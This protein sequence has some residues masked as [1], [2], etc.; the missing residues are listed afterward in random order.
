MNINLPIILLRGTAFFPSSEI[1][2]EMSNQ[3]SKNIIDTASLFHNN[4][5]IIA[6]QYRDQ[7]LLP[8]IGVVSSIV[9][10]EEMG[11]GNIR[12]KIV[13]KNRGIIKEYLPK[14]SEILE[15][16]V[17]VLPI[18]KNTKEET[19]MLM[20]LT[21]K[22]KEYVDEVPSASNSILS[23]MKCIHSLS[24]M[25]DILITYLNRPVEESRKYLE[26]LNPIVRAEELI[27]YLNSEISLVWKQKQENQVE[28]IDE[29]EN[30]EHVEQLNLKQEQI[31]Y[32]LKKMKDLVLPVEVKEKVQKEIENYQRLSFLSPENSMVHSYIEW[33]LSIPWNQYTKDE[34]NLKKVKQNLDKNHFSLSKVKMRMIEFLAVK[35]MNPHLQSPIL[36]F[37]G[38]PGVGK[39]SL[40]LSIANSLGRNFVKMSVGGLTD[41]SEII[42]HRRSYLGAKPGRI[43]QLL[44]KSKSMNPVFLIDEI[45][46]MVKSEKGDPTSSLLEVL[47]PV[48]NAY[49]RDLYIEEEIDLSAVLFITTAN[50]VEDIPLELKDR[51]EI[52]ILDGYTEIEKEQIASKYLL[53]QICKNYGLL[54]KKVILLKKALIKIIREYTQEAGVRDLQR[55]IQTIIRKMITE[56]IMNN[57][58]T[59]LYRIDVACVSKYL[60]NPVY[61]V[62]SFAYGENVGIVNGLA[63]MEY[64]GDCIA[65]EVQH[66]KG[67]GNLILTGTL[68]NVM[69]E[70]ALLS[71]S[72]IKSHADLFKIPI[73]EMT[74]D[75]IHI[76]LPKGAV[77]KEGPSAGVAVTTALI[78]SFSQLKISSKVAMTGEMT[79]LGDILPVGKA[80]EKLI[81]AY[82]RGMN[83]VFIPYG[84][85]HDVENILEMVTKK[86]KVY[87]IKTY[88][89]IYDILKENESR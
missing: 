36:C 14:T 58:K 26:Q 5:I 85:K 47:D 33:I 69:K 83:L 60:K 82:Q 16:L 67:N 77:K 71:L 52:I 39:T 37:V 70:S 48:Q 63:Y 38:P 3:E 12:V 31:E 30:Q 27:S 79:L 7:E 8:P 68:G 11:N 59:S 35:R 43:I 24:V 25:T 50:C 6:T 17:E 84:N 23:Q 15:T 42:G 73:G 10:K 72:Y 65:V 22:I 89:E 2:L 44:Q 76:H 56:N 62:A 66:F 40:A 32:F 45:D 19:E 21:L 49:F 87:F 88:K 46:K 57:R 1:K 34:E 51:L 78:S 4:E 41:E 29:R 64:G 28:Q 55:K 74:H 75:D 9:Y 13:G 20:K 18:Q 81:G 61:P 80:K 54:D 86:M 53:K